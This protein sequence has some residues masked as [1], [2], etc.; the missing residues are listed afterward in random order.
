MSLL[1]P[2]HE[3]ARAGRAREARSQ[4][5]RDRSRGGSPRRSRSA[6]TSIERFGELVTRGAVWGPVETIPPDPKTQIPDFV[7]GLSLLLGVTLSSSGLCQVELQFFSDTGS[8]SSVIHKATPGPSIFTLLLSSVTLLP[9]GVQMNPWITFS[10]SVSGI[11]HTSFPL[12]LYVPAISHFSPSTVNS[13]SVSSALDPVSSISPRP[14]SSPFA[15]RVIFS[16]ANLQLGSG[17][18]CP[19]V[20]GSFQLQLLTVWVTVI[21]EPVIVTVVVV[22]VHTQT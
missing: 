6:A 10:N 16:P 21:F 3:C 11:V 19:L 5:S 13:L 20:F 17:V 18:G 8:T 22:V 9:A 7:R 15:S 2:R 14:S 12:S 4:G 1:R